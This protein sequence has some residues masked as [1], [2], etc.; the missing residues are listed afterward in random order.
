[1]QWDLYGPRGGGIAE[2]EGVSDRLTV[3]E[4]TLAKA[5]GVIGGYIAA[6]AVLCDFIRCFASGFIFTTALPPAVAAGALASVQHLKS[7]TVERGRQQEVVAALRRRLDAAGLPTL[8]MPATLYRSSSGIPLYARGSAIH[9]SS[10]M[11]SICNRLTTPPCRAVLR[12]CA[13][14]RRHC[15]A[16]PTSTTSWHHSLRCGIN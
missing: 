13:S 1:M 14:R 2:R 8:R 6:T 7:S 15:T 12:G 10:T 9:Y 5:F 16:K 11:G 4:G 3:I